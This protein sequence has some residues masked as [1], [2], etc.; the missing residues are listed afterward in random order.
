M[1]EQRRVCLGPQ[2]VII[3]RA[4]RTSP[5]RPLKADNFYFLNSHVSKNHAVV[6]KD[7]ENVY[8]RDTNS[9]FGT[10][11]NGV[12]L[13]HNVRHELKSGDTLGLVVNRKAAVVRGWRDD[14]APGA[15]HS[16]SD[17]GCENSIHL[18]FDVTIEGDELTL[19]SK[20]NADW[21]RKASRKEEH[22]LENSPDESNEIEEVSEDD[23]ETILATK[24]EEHTVED[25]MEPTMEHT[26]EN[27]LEQEVVS[28]DDAP[29]EVKFVKEVVLESSEPTED[30]TKKDISE[31]AV[32]FSAEENP[33]EIARYL[34]SDAQLASSDEEN[35][36]DHE[37]QSDEEIVALDDADEFD[38]ID[39][40]VYQE[41]DFSNS[42]NEDFDDCSLPVL[43]N[44]DDADCLGDE[45]VSED[46]SDS[47]KISSISEASDLCS[48]EQDIS[49]PITIESCSCG[50]KRTFDEAELENALDTNAVTDANEHSPQPDT[51]KTKSITSTFLKEIGKGALYVMGTVVALIAYGRSLENQ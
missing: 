49:S 44:D 24:E 34:S 5:E 40:K 9:T 31:G 21:M 14:S 16:L 28:D 10:I 19:T 35:Y 15:N 38:A 22:D 20:K 27:P 25:T 30:Q 43:L 8:I 4:L 41:F 23:V 33:N 6:F 11:V 39:S 17:Y 48:D 12:L 1:T 29:E 37:E 50:V 26:V 47:D 2:P 51:K 3:G 45:T 18:Q 32:K 46:D 13:G 7:G 36:E 42:N